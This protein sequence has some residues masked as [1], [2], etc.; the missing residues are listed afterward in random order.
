MSAVILQN[1][2]IALESDSELILR[3]LSVLR[4]PFLLADPGA[5]AAF[6]LK[7]SP[8]PDSGILF[9]EES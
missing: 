3:N 7:I 1:P 9:S 2:Q 4:S 8:I 6:L 5:D